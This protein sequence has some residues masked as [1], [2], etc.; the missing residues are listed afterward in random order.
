[1]TKDSI[2]QILN[3]NKELIKDTFGIDNNG[4]DNIR[5]FLSKEHKDFKDVIDN[6]FLSDMSVSEKM[7]MYYLIGYDNGIR[8]RAKR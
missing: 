4:I 8:A 3:I 2:L 6:I 1:M 7:V 5:T